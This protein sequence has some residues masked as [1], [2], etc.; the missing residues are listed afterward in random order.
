MGNVDHSNDK[1]NSLELTFLFYY[2]YSE[3][4]GAILKIVGIV[5]GVLSAV[6][7]LI[8]CCCKYS[9]CCKDDEPRIVQGALGDEAEGVPLQEE[10]TSNV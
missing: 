9:S 6:C 2:F 8:G 1:R 5:V 7:T 3:S 10:A 4:V